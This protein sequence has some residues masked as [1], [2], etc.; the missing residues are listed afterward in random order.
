MN[1]LFLLILVL[2]C[3]PVS[4]AQKKEIDHTTYNQ[5]K[6]ISE[7]Q[8]SKNG[9]YTVYVVK[10]YRGDGFL[11]I[12]NHRTGRTDS[13]PRAEKAE[14]A[15]DD[16]FV[17]FHIR[18]GYDTLR[19]LEL[20]KVKKD[21]WVKDSLGVFYFSDH[22]LDKYPS[23]KYFKVAKETAFLA[24]L[25]EDNELKTNLKKK[26]KKNKKKDEEYT[27][28]GTVLVVVKDR[29]IASQQKDVL[30]I[31]VPEKGDHFVY[32]LH[33]T[34][35]KAD[36]LRIVAESV[37]KEEKTE[38]GTVFAAVEKIAFDHTG[39]S[40]VVVA[41]EDT[42]KHRSYALY[43]IDIP[44]GKLETYVNNKTTGNLDSTLHVS[45]NFEPYFSRDNSRIFFGVAEKPEKEPEDTLLTNEKSVL[46]VWNWKD[47]LIQPQQLKQ[48]NQ[49]LKSSRLAV[50]D[51]S[52]SVVI[53][54]LDTL[55]VLPNKKKDPLFLLGES[56]YAYEPEY[57]WN[58]PFQADYYKVDAKTGEKTILQRGVIN[59]A[60]LSPSGKY[61]VYYDKKEKG[62]VL[63]DLITGKESCM[64]CGSDKTVN[65]LEDVN[66]MPCEAGPLGIVG[67]NAE[68]SKCYIQSELDI[69]TY[70]IPSGKLINAT[71]YKGA[72]EKL[73]FQLNKFNRDSVYLDLPNLYMTSFSKTDKSTTVYNV[74]SLG[75][76]IGL[77]MKQR[78]DA[79]LS[80]F[81]KA[82]QAD[83]YIFRKSNVLLYPDIYKNTWINHSEPVKVSSANPQ[84]EEYNWTTVEL[85][86][87]KAYDGTDLEGLLY[88]PENFDPGKQYPL[89]VYYYEMY[90]DELHNHHTPR[91]TASIIFPTEYAS[92]GYVI[93]IPDIRYHPG[94]P[95]K[96]AYNCIMSGTDHVLKLLP[97]IDS[98]R[99]GLQ[100][101][102]WGGYQTAQ[103]ITM[104]KRY[105][106]AMAGAP[107][108]NMFSAYGG[109]RWGSGMNRQFQYERTQ[110]RIG[111][112]IW[113]APEKYIENSPLFKLPAVE[114]PLL[115]MH[116]DEDGAVPWYQGIELFMGLKR[117]EKPVWLL[118]YNGDDHNLM[119]SANRID[120]SIRMRQF[121]DFYLLN[122]P[123]PK[124]MK[125]GVPAVLK[126]KSYGLDY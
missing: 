87:W 83:D 30:E 56:T 70:E 64:T 54:G 67:F 48:K 120:L 11:Y 10:P 122:K 28:K 84:Q 101:Q 123:E 99:M 18:P 69:W 21:K 43:K 100:G 117:L 2:L 97:N 103:L 33:K 17:A 26:K 59:Y 111:A 42:V 114:T 20:K 60:E 95:A 119:K 51:T 91:P 13:I 90:S 68:E 89:L 16:S 1:K 35:K 79:A 38:Y 49:K 62:L 4:W 52:G 53:L 6:S 12:V 22:H 82:E 106:A 74:T 118:N 40:F 46:D 23:L 44:S 37:D 72:K 85:V 121:F 124:W 105:R 66:G 75:S 27:S 50:Y 8:I 94:T 14:F 115:I 39:K 32:Y 86:K 77:N 34:I 113:E 73:V 110:S 55:S 112:T 71:A 104:T 58:Y 29:K 107:V 5:W 41:S 9:N 96:D 24:F 45:N 92:A 81:K 3:M 109:I 57:S 65:W 63:Q 126:G 7:P 19:K 31:Q 98:T 88:K 93:L 125:E 47:R 25:K 78:E 102:S 116:N 61:F 108:G 36:Q 76:E 80:S 15:G